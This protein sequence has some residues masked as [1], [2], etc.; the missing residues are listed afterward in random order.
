MRKTEVI[1][2][3]KEPVPVQVSSL[4]DALAEIARLQSENAH[5]KRDE[6]TGFY[7]KEI[8]NKKVDEMLALAHEQKTTVAYMMIDCDRFKSINDTY[9][10]RVGD[11]VIT[12]I[13]DVL[14]AGVRTYTTN[15]D[16][17]RRRGSLDGATDLVGRVAI[18]NE[19]TVEIGRVGSGDEFGVA[20]YGVNAAQ[21]EEIAGR[22]HHALR[23]KPYMTKDGKTIQLT[24]SIGIATT[25]TETTRTELY[26]G[27]DTALYAAKANGRNCTRIHRREGQEALP[28]PAHSA[29]AQ[30]YAS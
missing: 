4:E 1:P 20:L 27:A 29:P 14:R 10:H 26:G 9:G 7:R 2:F 3:G 30:A 25:E 22:M 24:M 13:A 19:D 28:A 17:E 6:M 16:F 5:L 12:H 21:A 15:P 23:A 11:E 8:F 18:V